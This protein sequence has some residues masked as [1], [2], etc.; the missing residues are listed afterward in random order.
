MRKARTPDAEADAA[1]GRRGV[2]QVSLERALSK[3]GL[4]TRTQARALVREGRVTVD[5]R[6]VTDPLAP[7]V[8]ERAG[9]AIDGLPARRPEP[10]TVLLNKPRG[11]L[12][13][14]SDPRGRP[15]VYGCL[16]GCNAHLVPVGRLDSASTGLLLLTNDTRLAAWLTDPAHAVPRIYLITVRGELTADRALAATAGVADAGELLA[17]RSVT[18]RKLS[19]RETHL[20][21]ELTEGKNREIRRLFDAL[22]HQ[23]TA[24]KRVAFGGLSL[25]LLA[26][27]AWRVVPAA[28]LAAAFPDAPLSPG[29]RGRKR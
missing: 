10:L 3:L 21:V 23:V 11:V 6:A 27:G 28:E 9:I 16:A 7:I 2:G 4:A 24:L 19:R 13:T 5:G 14:R 22:G 18:V 12:T 8:P 17:A 26:P 15:T 20:T 1:P 25:G 29:R